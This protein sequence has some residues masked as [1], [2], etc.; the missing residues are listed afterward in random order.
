M[1]PPDAL[2]ALAEMRDANAQYE[3]AK[4][5]VT[6]MAACYGLA[7]AARRYLRALAAAQQTP[8]KFFVNN[9]SGFCTHCCLPMGSHRLQCLRNFVAHETP[10]PRPAARV[11]AD[12]ST[13]KWMREL[14]AQGATVFIQ[15][16]SG[17]E[18]VEVVLPEDTT[19]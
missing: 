3:A 16:S 5:Q 13:A 2:R 6:I 9:G 1:T 7:M 11:V 4:D 17:G 12:E 19:P 18:R 15:H 8:Q 10:A 14:R